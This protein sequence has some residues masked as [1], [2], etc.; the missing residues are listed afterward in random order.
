M[1]VCVTVEKGGDRFSLSSC[2]LPFLYRVLQ[3]WQFAI[4]L[5]V[6]ENAGKIRQGNHFLSKNHCPSSYVTAQSGLHFVNFARKQ[7]FAFCVV[8]R[9]GNSSLFGQTNYI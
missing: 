9:G 2:L 8:C 5:R 4:V 6:I 7:Y 3:T 1:C